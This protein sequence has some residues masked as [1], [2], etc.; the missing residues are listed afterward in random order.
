MEVK[1]I[2]RSKFYVSL[3][4]IV[5]VGDKKITCEFT[6]GMTSPASINGSFKTRD[7]GVQKALESHPWFN[8]EF[9]LEKTITGGTPS[10]AENKEPVEDEKKIV[11]K[12]VNANEAREE[13]N[14][15]YGVSFSKIKNMQ[16]I[17]AKAK[18]LG[19]VYPDW[20]IK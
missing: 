2:Y 10:R 13:L 14:K 9:F 18:E 17:L 4:V 6:G 20:E 1:K 16:N 5:A 12:A 7:A 15:V 11:S 8:R 3:T 19:I